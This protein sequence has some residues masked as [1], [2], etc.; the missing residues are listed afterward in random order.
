M[1]TAGGSFLSS[2][3]TQPRIV[4]TGGKSSPL[5]NCKSW[6]TASTFAST[7]GLYPSKSNLSWPM[8]PVEYHASDWIRIYLEKLLDT[9]VGINAIDV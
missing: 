9:G 8:A 3:G 7:V 5:T 1:A 2:L 4:P 6:L